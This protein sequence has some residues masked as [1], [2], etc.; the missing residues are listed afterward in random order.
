[1]IDE[2]QFLSNNFQE[3]LLFWSFLFC[4][5]ILLCYVQ[6]WSILWIIFSSLV[7]NWKIPQKFL[8]NLDSLKSSSKV[9]KIPQFK[10]IS[11]KVR[12]L[13]K[14]L[15]STYSIPQFR[16]KRSVS[17]SEITVI[18]KPSYVCFEINIFSFSEFSGHSL[19]L[20]FH[21]PQY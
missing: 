9:G 15:E 13:K 1:M 16:R 6:L 2:Q 12:A 17:I 10:E 14:L 8:K 19:I 18:I 3:F 20:V 11:S 4:Y 7:L 21:D 5:G